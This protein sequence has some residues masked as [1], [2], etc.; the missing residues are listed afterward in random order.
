MGS[1]FNIPGEFDDLERMRN[2]EEDALPKM[3]PEERENYNTAKQFQEDL[4]PD[5]KLMG[6]INAFREEFGITKPN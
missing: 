1:S 3:T 6:R 4:P 5:A 2:E